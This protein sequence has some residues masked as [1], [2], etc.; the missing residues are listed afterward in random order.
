[1]D[2]NHPNAGD[3][4]TLKKDTGLLQGKGR[5]RGERGRNWSGGGGSN[6]DDV[7]GSAPFAFPFS[8]SLL[9]LL[10]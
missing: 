7:T 2:V 10:L 9:P 4:R 8:S 1:M 6:D 5:E 3:E